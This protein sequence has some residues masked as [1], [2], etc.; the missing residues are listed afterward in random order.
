MVGGI[1]IGHTSK[2]NGKHTTCWDSG[3]ASFILR[4]YGLKEAIGIDANLVMTVG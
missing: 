2:V 3:D 1:L 4:F